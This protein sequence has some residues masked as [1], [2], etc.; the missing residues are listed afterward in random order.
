MIRI[1]CACRQAIKVPEKYAGQN[2]K[3]PNCGD[4]VSVPRPPVP[5]PQQQPEAVPGKFLQGLLTLLGCLSTA[6]GM[7]M[8]AASLLVDD[9][10]LHG[11]PPFVTGMGFF[12]ASAIL[13]R[14][15][16]ILQALQSDA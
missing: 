4:P 1:T 12:T 16:R 13:D 5:P 3:C 15:D 10:T 8:I 11:L 9:G 14:L 2:V 7:L 6:V